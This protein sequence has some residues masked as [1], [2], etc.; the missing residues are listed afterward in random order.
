MAKFC[1]YVDIKYNPNK[2]DWENV[3][4]NGHRGYI[5]FSEDD[6]AK[7]FDKK[8]EMVRNKY[9]VAKAD[10]DKRANDRW[11]RQ[12]DEFTELIL[13]YEEAVEI[14]NEVFEEQFFK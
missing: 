3:L 9:N 7:E 12:S 4:T 1:A 10:A 8:L 13:W 6:L 2:P 11:Y 5:S 14:A